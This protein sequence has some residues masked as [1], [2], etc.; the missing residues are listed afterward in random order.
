MKSETPV[1]EEEVKFPTPPVPEKVK[2]ETPIILEQLEK[3]RDKVVDTKEREKKG[4][5]VALFSLSPQDGADA[6]EQIDVTPAQ[7]LRLGLTPG[8][9]FWRQALGEEDAGSPA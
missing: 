6:P 5:P 7:L 8:S 4:A 1:H 9:H 3:E 2:S